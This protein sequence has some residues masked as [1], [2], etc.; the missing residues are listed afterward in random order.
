[1]LIV[2]LLILFLLLVVRLKMVLAGGMVNLKTGEA[3]LLQATDG[4]EINVYECKELSNDL[5][6]NRQSARKI[7]N[8]HGDKCHKIN[9][10]P[11]Q[12]SDIPRLARNLGD[13][14]RKRLAFLSTPEG[15]DYLLKSIELQLVEEPQTHPEK[16]GNYIVMID[17]GGF[18]LDINFSKGMPIYKKENTAHTMLFGVMGSV[19]GMMESFLPQLEKQLVPQIETIAQH[20]GPVFQQFLQEAKKDSVDFESGN[21]LAA[22]MRNVFGSENLPPVQVEVD[23]L[24]LYKKKLAICQEKL[25]GLDFSSS[26]EGGL[27]KPTGLA[28]CH[29]L[30]TER[31][32]VLDIV[33]SEGEV[34]RVVDDT[35][36][37]HSKPN[38]TESFDAAGRGKTLSSVAR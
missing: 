21:S 35:P 36:R 5:V 23:S 15:K 28:K 13:Q 1:M 17:V 25:L 38:L 34:N 30:L 18:P 19:E 4:D 29:A 7:L 10:N 12:S 3:F 22:F 9:K 14:V 33:G 16:P 32:E 20:P 27:A 11:F 6:P 37:T 26:G 24:T 8:N 2:R 31:L